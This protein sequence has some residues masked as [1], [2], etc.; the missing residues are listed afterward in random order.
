LPSDLPV[1]DHHAHLHPSHEGI[2]AAR[3]FRTAGGTHLFLAT[4]TY[5]SVCPMDID[6]YRRQFETT[7]ALARQVQAATGVTAYV[8]VAPYPI[9]LLPQAERLGLDAAVGLQEAALDLAGHWVAEQR[10]VALGEI[11][12]PHF[13]VDPATLPS[14]ERVFRRALEVARDSGVP[15]VVHCE[16]LT[17]DGYRGLAAFASSIGFPLGRLIKH[18]ARSYVPAAERLGIVPSFLARREAV[19]DARADPGPWFLETDFLD[20]PRRP[21]AVLDLATIPRRAVAV[22]GE[23][24][25]G[26]ELLHRVFVDSV[27]SVYGF[28]PQVP[29][30]GSA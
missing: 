3:R 19:R 12:R 10:A 6:G 25:E 1:V 18:Y 14:V 8:V 15:A 16:D 9:D 20:D 17:P 23:G 13:P 29:P 2:E 4:Q 30:G 11:G 28:A 7:E 26:I 27:R 24:A 22:A 21:G 5:E